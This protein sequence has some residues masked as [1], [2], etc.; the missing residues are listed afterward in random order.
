MR[1]MPMRSRTPKLIGTTGPA[2]RGSNASWTRTRSSCS[3]P[4]RR[5]ASS[6]ASPPMSCTS[7]NGRAANSISTTL[8]SMRLGGPCVRRRGGGEVAAMRELNALYADAFEDAETYR[9]DRPGGAWLERKRDKEAIIRLV[10]EAEGRVVG[11]I[12]A[13]ELPKLERACSEI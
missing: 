4:K 11:G 1:S 13:Y 3:S 10:A 8:P 2:T 6:A 12:T 5:G 7:S 9:H